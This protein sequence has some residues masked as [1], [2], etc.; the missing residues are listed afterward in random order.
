MK[1]ALSNIA[2]SPFDH[3]DELRALPAMGY[4]GIEVAPSRVWEASWDGLTPAQVEAYRHQVE[5]AGLRIVGLHS[6]FFDQPDLGLFK[7]PEIE[8]RTLDFLV[9]LSAVC[10]DLG[11][12]TLIWGSKTARTKGERSWDQ[13]KAETLDFLGRLSQAIEDHGTVY[14]FEPLEPDV[15]DFVN[16]ALESL[17]LVQTLDHPSFGLQ[18]DAKALVGNGELTNDLVAACGEAICHVHANEPDLGVLDP[19][20]PVDHE[21]FA[22]FLKGVGYEGYVTAEQR[23]LNA[24]DPLDDAARSAAVLE[25]LYAS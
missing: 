12:R 6:L 22:G 14:C 15:A 16:S 17:D 18:L 7:G 24:D 1:P 20:G 9:H 11:G 23:M 2:L 25:G 10:R 4:K 8:E 21:A 5:N 19:D 3:A 13:A